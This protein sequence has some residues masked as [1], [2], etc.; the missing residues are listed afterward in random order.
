MTKAGDPNTGGN[1]MRTSIHSGEDTLWEPNER[2]MLYWL[3]AS[4]SSL[5]GL[6]PVCEP[7][8]PASAGE[9]AIPH[10]RI[11]TGFLGIPTVDQP[12]I[13][14]GEKHGSDQNARGRLPAFRSG[15]KEPVFL[16]SH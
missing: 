13:A 12:A 1:V 6:R 2:W 14:A 9:S 16:A 4:A 5:S 3:L 11:P 15:E 10:R 8:R 7:A